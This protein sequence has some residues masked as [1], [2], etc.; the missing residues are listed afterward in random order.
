VA[1]T[2]L[3]S[4]AGEANQVR[5]GPGGPIY[6][7]VAAARFLGNSYYSTA[8]K[9][10]ANCNLL[11][12]VHHNISRLLTVVG[13]SNDPSILR[14]LWIVG[15]ELFSFGIGGSTVMVLHLSPGAMSRIET[16][17]Y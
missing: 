11:L 14:D 9:S 3:A 4:L 5:V 15:P 17:R 2:S 1:S 7:S 16:P 8:S 12:A 10:E 13:S 6:G